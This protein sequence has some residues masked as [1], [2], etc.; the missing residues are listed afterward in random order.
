MPNGRSFKCIHL[1]APWLFEMDNVHAVSNAC[2]SQELESLNCCDGVSTMAKRQRAWQRVREFHAFHSQYNNIDNSSSSDG[3]SG[4]SGN[5]NGGSYNSGGRSRSN[6]RIIFDDDNEGS[7]MVDFI[8][9]K[10]PHAHVD[11]K[12]FATV[13]V[14]TQINFVKQRDGQRGS[15]VSGNGTFLQRW[16]PEVAQSKG[17]RKLA[18]FVKSHAFSNIF[19]AILVCSHPQIR[20][21]YFVIKRHFSCLRIN[22]NRNFVVWSSFFLY[23]F[24]C[25]TLWLSSLFLT[26][27]QHNIALA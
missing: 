7:L 23:I 6:S 14:L 3:S 4:S 15:T 21:F 24:G 27:G 17:F 10:D 8:A 11:R 20:V 5:A 25:S 19:A 2:Y 18:T 26:G 12:T 16:A 22:V 9:S 1:R 13:C